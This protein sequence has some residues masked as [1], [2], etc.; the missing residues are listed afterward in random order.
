MGIP[1]TVA[2][3]GAG[4][5]E[6][7]PART[8]QRGLEELKRRRQEQ[9]EAL[10]QAAGEDQ[11]TIDR[12]TA[13]VHSLSAAI[14]AIDQARGK[15]RDRRFAVAG[16]A[17]AVLLTGTLLLL[18]RP[19]AEILLDTKAS[20]VSFI[21]TTPFAPLRGVVGVAS[22]ELAGLTKVRLEGAA[23]TVAGT[24]EDLQ[25]GV[26]SVTGT[27]NPGSIGF[28][29]LL[30]PVGTLVE[31]TETGAGKTI[32]LRFQY[33]F[34]EAAALDLDVTGDVVIHVKGQ[35]RRNANFPAPARITAV[36]A[37]DAQLVVQFNSQDAVF[38]TPVAAKSVMWSRDA[39][40]ASRQPEG[41]REESSILSG[42]LS[43]EEFKDRFVNLRNGEPVH[44]GRSSGQIR[45]L[46]SDG[47]TISCQFDGVVAELSIGEGSQ[48]QN[49]MPTWL[50]WLRQR[51][52]LVQFW[53]LAVYLAGLGLTVG[54]WWRESQ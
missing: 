43:L 6:P 20:G 28:D 52:A 10:A 18:H 50:E 42:K 17:A 1:E 39:R 23:E 45:Q 2:K 15:E 21:V 32:E 4:A 46:R 49:L 16:V 26:Q 47:Q 22:V 24:D 36:P 44:L 7:R 9:I 25:L 29:S 12:L 5:A 33:P 53:A 48:R 41:A 30:I 35:G 8:A 31:F 27:S 13:L 34:G 54:H 14:N 38:P 51:D 19:S 37:G 40:I 3:T 11:A